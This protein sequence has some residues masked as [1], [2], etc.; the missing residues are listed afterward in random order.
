MI[1]IMMTMRK[2]YTYI[3]NDDGGG[4]HINHLTING[5][6]CGGGRRGMRRGEG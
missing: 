1:I 6:D 4:V 5:G 3:K 2:L